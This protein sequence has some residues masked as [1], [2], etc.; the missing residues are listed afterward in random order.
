M[1]SKKIYLESDLINLAK[2]RDFISRKA[3]EA[4]ASES[5]VTRI[6]ISCDEWNANIIEH[7]L[8]K[9]S[10]KVFSIECISEEGKFFIIYEHEGEEF[11]PIEQGA[12]DVDEHF[13]ESKERGLGIFI[14]REMMDEI[15]HEYIDNKINRLTLI[16]YLK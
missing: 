8:G 13:S 5:D 9:G 2:A 6:E 4:G 12:V 11:N 10:E 15:H 14:M 16:K 1:E 7:A 3:K